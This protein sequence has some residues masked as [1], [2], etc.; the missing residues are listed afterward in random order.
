MPANFKEIYLFAPVRDWTGGFGF[1]GSSVGDLPSMLGCSHGSADIDLLSIVYQLCFYAGS[2]SL[3]GD[4]MNF[5]HGEMRVCS[6][7][8]SPSAYDLMIGDVFCQLE[9]S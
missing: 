4:D 1:D 2:W 6:S 3:E 7:A 9:L 8:S 5:H